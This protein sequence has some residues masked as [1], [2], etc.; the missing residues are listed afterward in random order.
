MWQGLRLGWRSFSGS[1]PCLAAPCPGLSCTALLLLQT[2]HTYNFIL[3]ARC[4]G[5]WG[6]RSIQRLAAWSWQAHGACLRV[7]FVPGES[8][9]RQEWV[10]GE[11]T[12][13][14][15]RKQKAHWGGGGVCLHGGG[16]EFLF[17]ARKS[18]VPFFS[19]SVAAWGL[20]Q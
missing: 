1:L 9:C 14:E 8:S 18:K 10:S 11:V 13:R 16:Q 12:K 20:G 6:S 3:S 2:Q 17:F 15:I 7:L 5:R 4:L 19:A